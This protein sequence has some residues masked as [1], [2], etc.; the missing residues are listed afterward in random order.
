M[1]TRQATVLSR[2]ALEAEIERIRRAL[3][4]KAAVLLAGRVDPSDDD[5]IL[6]LSR[7]LDGLLAVYARL[8]ARES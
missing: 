1:G 6:R 2:D 5:D 3:N 7:H 4:D 8:F